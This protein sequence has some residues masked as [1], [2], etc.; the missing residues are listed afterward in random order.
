MKY[1]LI[2]SVAVL[3][4]ACNAKYEESFLHGD[5]VKQSWLNLDDGSSIDQKLDFSFSE[6]RRYKV[7][8]GQQMEEGKYWL[9]GEYLHTVEDGRAEKKVRILTLTQDSLVFEMNRGGHLE[10]VTLKKNN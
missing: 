9:A 7:D 2:L 6:D 3:F 5:W 8:Y 4:L 10:K 1:S